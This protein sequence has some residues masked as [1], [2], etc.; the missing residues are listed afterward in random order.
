MS[1]LSRP[2]YMKPFPLIDDYGL[3]HL[4]YHLFRTE[5]ASQLYKLISSNTWFSTSDNFDPSHQQYNQDVDYAHQALYASIQSDLENNVLHDLPQQLSKVTALAWL[6]SRIGQSGS[7]VTSKVLETLT[8]LGMSEEAIQRA[9]TIPDSVRRAEALIRIGFAAYYIRSHPMKEEA[10]SE[11]EVSFRNSP[12]GFFNNFIETKAKFVLILSFAGEKQK[13]A[14]VAYELSKDFHEIEA[15]AIGVTSTAQGAMAIAWATV[16]EL[17]KSAELIQNIYFLED[18]LKALRDI[19]E[20]SLSIGVNDISPFVQMALDRIPKLTSPRSYQFLGEIFAHT[21]RVDQVDDILQRDDLDHRNRAWICRAR[22]ANAQS[23]NDAPGIQRWVAQII[24]EAIQISEPLTRLRLCASLV[25]DKLPFQP[26]RQ[27]DGLLIHIQKDVI[28]LKDHLDE[29]TLGLCALALY[30]LGDRVLAKDL[31]DQATLV[32][33]PPDDWDETYG[34]IQVSRRLGDIQDFQ[35][36]QEVLEIA[37]IRTDLWQ[38]AE[39]ICSIAIAAMHNHEKSI[40][41]KAQASLEE[42][43]Q[44]GPSLSQRPNAFGALAVWEFLRS[45]DVENPKGKSFINQAI[46]LL[47]NDED[48]ASA[49][50]YLAL[51]LS[52]YHLIDRALE[53]IDLSIQALKE[54]VDPNMLARVISEIVRVLITLNTSYF[55][56]ELWDVAE[57]ISDDWLQGEAYFWLAGLQAIQGQLGEAQKTFQHVFQLDIWSEIDLDEIELGLVYAEKADHFLLAVDSIEWPSTKAALL[58]AGLAILLADPKPWH[59]NFGVKAIDHLDE[60]YTEQRAL[61]FNMIASG[62]EK[63]DFG[64]SE[65]VNVYMLALAHSKSR[66]VGEPWAIFRSFCPFIQ[67]KGYPQLAELVWDEW[68]KIN[69]LFY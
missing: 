27:M 49:L 48:R 1:L 25:I 15:T 9:R 64:V 10:W 2:D 40:A 18:Q 30:A 31:A 17:T 66:I 54:E 24:N 42:I 12:R 62:M 34:L 19:V 26:I 63:L 20:I 23:I 6:T 50:A 55:P 4:A 44:D 5:N 21:G 56:N 22:A 37:S 52:Q 13:A 41:Q 57:L 28:S 67:S 36:L 35:R 51:T 53:A 61:F 14:R 46:A 11:A 58:F 38:K 3:Q 59:I 45:G 33:I 60:A 8:L 29:V 69:R 7:R 43:R 47:E 65:Y 39:I 32:T 16:G 68:R